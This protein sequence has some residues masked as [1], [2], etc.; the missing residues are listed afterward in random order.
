M[1][2][3]L[4]CAALL[5]GAALT[6]TA[7]GNDDSSG[8]GL[9]T[10]TSTSTSTTDTSTSPTSGT[11]SA[12]G[13]TTSNGSASATTGPATA[14]RVTDGWVKAADHGAMSAAFGTLHNDTDAPVRIPGVSSDRGAMQMHETVMDGGAMTMKEVPS[15][16]VPAHGTFELKPG[17]N[18]IMFMGLTQPLTT[19]STVALTLKTGS[20]PLHVDLPVRPFTGAKEHYQSDSAQPSHSGGS[21]SSGAMSSHAG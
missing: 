3:T 15:Y 12:A 17:G 9:S 2:H 4:T 20:G 1:S 7:C 8:S 10:G 14:L 6:L 21:T 18:H 16:T 19:G 11:S 5:A 13:S